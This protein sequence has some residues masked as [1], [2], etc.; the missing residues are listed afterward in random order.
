[1]ERSRHGT[2]A[3]LS[4]PV[5]WKIKCGQAAVLIRPWSCSVQRW[6]ALVITSKRQALPG[7]SGGFGDF[8]PGRRA[9]QFNHSG[10]SPWSE[11]VLQRSPDTSSKKLMVPKSY[12]TSSW[13]CA[14]SAKREWRATGKGS[15]HS[16]AHSI[17]FLQRQQYSSTA[18]FDAAG[19]IP[20][21]ASNASLRRSRCGSNALHSRLNS[22]TESPKAGCAGRWFADLYLAWWGRPPSCERTS[23]MAS[24]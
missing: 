1:M 5:A 6:G 14:A 10:Q 16:V 8:H 11:H 7:R 3:W 4:Q 20:K 22:S 2:T 24:K 9:D 13:W 21:T 15:M 12:S 23:S 17:A 19:G 18:H